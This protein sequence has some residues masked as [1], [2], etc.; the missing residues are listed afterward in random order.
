MQQLRKKLYEDR[1]I[2]EHA[3]IRHKAQH[4]DAVFLKISALLIT[5]AAAE[6]FANWYL[7]ER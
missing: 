3:T 4:V 2:H 5:F 7:Q 6:I 1:F